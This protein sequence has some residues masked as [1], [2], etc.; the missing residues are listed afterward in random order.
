MA[1]TRGVV[2]T[3]RLA[4][5]GHRNDNIVENE[6]GCE[7]TAKRRSIQN[8]KICVLSTKLKERSMYIEMYVGLTS[9]PFS[10][11]DREH[12]GCTYCNVLLAYE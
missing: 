8:V 1:V 12:M 6:V 11:S 10:V 3:L 2:A 7:L 5:L 4:N 9:L